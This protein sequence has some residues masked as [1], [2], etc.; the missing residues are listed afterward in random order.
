MEALRIYVADLAEYNNGTLKGI[1]I[2]LPCDNIMDKVQEMLGS[3]E[4][5]AIHDYEL[6]FNISEYEDL[7]EINDIAREYEDLEE[8]DIKRVNYLI[9]DQGVN[10]KRA[11]CEYENVDIYENMTLEDLAYELVEEGCFGVIDPAIANYIDYAAIARD[12]SFDYDQI[13]NDLFRAA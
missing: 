9:N 3:N 13:D 11:I 1:W 12:L 8:C 5:W 6:P 2:D 4:E 7:E 10:F